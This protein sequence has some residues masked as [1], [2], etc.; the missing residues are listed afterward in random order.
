MCQYSRGCMGRIL[1]SGIALDIGRRYLQRTKHTEIC[2]YVIRFADWMYLSW[3][4]LHVRPYG[5]DVS[6]E[7]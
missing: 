4:S 3:A 7:G 5:L 6:Q 1:C 2:P